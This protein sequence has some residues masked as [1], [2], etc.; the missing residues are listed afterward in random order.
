VDINLS[1]RC[2]LNGRHRVGKESYVFRFGILA[3]LAE[4][5]SSCKRQD[6][7]IR[8]RYEQLQIAGEAH[9]AG[10]WEPDGIIAT[11]SDG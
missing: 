2:R 3:D 1:R 11:W 9:H 4:L 5:S 6:A 10:G 8:R 7:A